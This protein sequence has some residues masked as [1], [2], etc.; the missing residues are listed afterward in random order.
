MGNYNQYLGAIFNVEEKV[1]KS[2]AKAMQAGN[3]DSVS[4]KF[5]FSFNCCRV[6]MGLVIS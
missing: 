2:I 1:C 6:I 4:Y 5:I 3:S